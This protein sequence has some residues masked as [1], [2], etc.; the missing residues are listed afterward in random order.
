MD[1]Q[2]K[3]KPINEKHSIKEA[4]L[5]VFIENQIIKPERFRG[6]L[7]KE[8]KDD[9]Q[10]FNVVSNLKFTI[11][12]NNSGIVP[13]S[14]SETIGFRFSA[15]KNG[16]LDRIFQAINE[17]NR[18]A[19]SF[20][21]LNYT[22]WADF[23]MEFKNLMRSLASFQPGYFV[24]AISLHY[25]DQFEWLDDSIAI[26]PALIFKKETDYLPAEFFRSSKT[27]FLIV[28]E[29]DFIN[30]F[31][32][33]VYDRIEIVVSANDRP[34]ITISH[35]VTVPLSELIDLSSI[36]DSYNEELF[37]NVHK[38]N[39]EFLRNILNLDICSMIKI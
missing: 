36:A 22:R 6:L 38:R 18:N 19:I 13:A 21:C 33:K 3:I 34:I 2:Q 29:K 24:N 20:H 4:V 11:K 28:T 30:P 5:S 10:H 37:A 9:Y 7:D 23:F 8:L 14:N 17:E 26:D 16:K 39:K 27:Q 12:Q 25:I 35:N 32:P 31:S 15:F 1:L